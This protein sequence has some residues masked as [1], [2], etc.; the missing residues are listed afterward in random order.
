MSCKL[1][2][3]SPLVLPKGLSIL[4]EDELRG[5]A[6]TPLRELAAENVIYISAPPT[7]DIPPVDL[8]DGIQILKVLF[9][10]PSAFLFLSGLLRHRLVG[11]RA[12]QVLRGC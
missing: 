2:S 10:P 3:I 7:D 9:L 11:Q 5:L 8:S 4:G 12:R 6:G 1:R